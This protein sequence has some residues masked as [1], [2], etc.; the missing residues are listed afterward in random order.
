[1]MLCYR[2]I[3]A[4]MCGVTCCMSGTHTRTSHLGSCCGVEQRCLALLRFLISA[5]FRQVALPL[6]KLSS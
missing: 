1:M 3:E 5:L 2:C 4:A 6:Q